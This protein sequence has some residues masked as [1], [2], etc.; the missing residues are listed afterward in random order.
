MILPIYAYGN[1]VLKKATED[2]PPVNLVEVVA[3]ASDMFETMYA[4]NGVGL[5]APQV[6]S[7][8]RVFVLDAEVFD[9]EE[10]PGF[11]RTLINARIIA[12][13]GEICS[14]NEGCLSIPEIRE[15]VERPS[16]VTVRYLDENL[17]EKVEEFTAMPARILQHEYDHIE[18]KLFTDRISPLR[19]RLLQRRLEEISRGM[20]H[21]KYK[22]K[23]P[24][25]KR[26]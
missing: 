11:K 13:G 16:K 9:P 7:T 5:A 22:M 18:G 24:P 21:V 20:V 6:G 8:H 25:A 3:L 14:F 1:Q 2:V 26:K 4:A 10:Y 12:E 15:E 19:K 17:E 23:F